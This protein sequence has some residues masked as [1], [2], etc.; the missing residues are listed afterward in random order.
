MALEKP[1]FVEQTN[2]LSQPSIYNVNHIKLTTSGQPLKVAC[3]GSK[4]QR[5]NVQRRMKRQLKG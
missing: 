2:T 5:F 4:V 1:P 3:G